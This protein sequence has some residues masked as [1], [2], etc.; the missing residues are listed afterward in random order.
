[1]GVAM[2]R[3]IGTRLARVLSRVL[4]AFPVRPVRG[5]PA[6][7]RLLYL[8]SAR[9]QRLAEDPRPAT[10]ARTHQTRFLANS[11]T[12]EEAAP[13]RVFM[14]S[15]MLISA[16]FVALVVWAAV[17]P[18]TEK[19]M[20]QGEIVPEGS[21]YVVQHLE[22]GII[23]R[24]FVDN[25]QVVDAGEPLIQ[26]DPAA[27]QAEL[28]QMRTRGAALALRAERLRAFS[29]G[30]RPNFSAYADEYPDLVADQRDILRLGNEAA[31]SQRLV[32]DSRIGQRQTEIDVLKEKI[33]SLESQAEIVEEELAMRAKLLERGLVSRILFLE[34]KREANRLRGEIA[35]ASATIARTRLEVTEATNNL[36]EFENRSRDEALTEMGVVSAELAQV[37]EALAKLEDRVQRLVVVAP[38]HGI[39]N[40]LDDANVGA[41]I[42][43]GGTLMEIVPL[44]DEMIVEAQ[45]A[46]RDIGHLEIGQEVDVKFMTFDYARYGSV[47]GQL[48]HLSANS[49]ATETGEVFFKAKIRL[50]QGYVGEDPEKNWVL[51]GMTV[52]A[53]IVTGSKSFLQYLL[54]PIYA[55]MG[56]AFSE[57]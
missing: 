29:E 48:D 35:Q 23:S 52:Q 32:L 40:G 5:L 43:P 47:L 7:L 15:L 24:I 8:K 4:A 21:V 51:P 39:V 46:A 38:M 17:T 25:G 53:D 44:E 16:L 19:V 11:I 28:E 30:R 12:L 56:G 6:L 3:A 45:I 34:N 2:T 54:K 10:H 36:V 22:G 14:L 20:A 42:E 49:F 41:V 27:S 31:H 26:L 9:T 57:R 33:A 50:T 18:A 1:M 37:T 55:S 13:P